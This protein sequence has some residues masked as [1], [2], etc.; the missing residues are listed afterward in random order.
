MRISEQNTN[1]VHSA[2]AN[3]EKRADDQKTS[4]RF[5]QLLK[6][7]EEKRAGD[8]K[9]GINGKK[10]GQNTNP[11]SPAT[12]IDPTQTASLA[13][14]NSPFRSPQAFSFS[15]GDTGKI[16]QQATN[17]P[18]QI[19]KLS[20]ELAHQIDVVKSG[21]VTEGVNITFDSK[22]LEGLQVQIR[23]ENGEMSI[24]FVTQSDNVSKLL[25]QNIAEFKES[26]AAKGV[27][28]QKI[29][30][31]NAQTSSGLREYKHA[32]N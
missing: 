17:A 6:S 14:D 15:S 16:A 9:D 24:R 22:A 30:I 1:G 13:V 26:L 18:H 11:K 2:N 3:F 25:S 4:D 32:R 23:Q 5:S 20:S 31:A 27:K 10:E 28:V 12:T 29:S 21:G 7:K 19:E 8:D